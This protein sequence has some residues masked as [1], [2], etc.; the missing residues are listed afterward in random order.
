[1]ERSVITELDEQRID[2]L[3]AY[4][5]EYSERN[6]ENIKNLFMQKTAGKHKSNK[7]ILLVAA[8]AAVL[9][10]FSGIALAAFT[11]LDFGRI[12]NSFFNNP[13]AGSRIEVGYS[14][15]SDGM[16]IT[17][18]TA[19]VDEGSAY[20]MLE[21]KD[22]DGRR[23]SDSMRV[24]SETV[25]GMSTSA[26]VYDDTENKAT[27]IVTQYLAG[28]VEIGRTIK[29]S[30]DAVLSG[31]G[32]FENQPLDFDIAA[33]ATGKE[34]VSVEEWV[35]AAG[36]NSYG[37]TSIEETIMLLKPGEMEVV[38]DGINWAVI[39]NF[40]V[41]DGRLHLQY[42]QTEEYSMSYNYGFEHLSL[43]DVN[44]EVIPIYF[45][46]NNSDFFELVFDIGDMSDLASLQLAVS[47]MSIKHII[48]GPWELSFSVDKEMPKKT[49]KA[50]PADSPF[51]IGIE[52]TT[53]PMSTTIVMSLSDQRQELT[54]MED[55]EMI[56]YMMGY[57]QR[58]V[59]YVEGFPLPHLT[60]DDGSIIPLEIGAGC[61]YDIDTGWAEYVSAYFDIEKLHSITFCEQEYLFSDTD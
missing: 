45:S 42:R 54:D 10:A 29:L 14:V 25:L 27:I 58:V 22:L 24:M 13:S 8:I 23:L 56:D 31:L 37:M 33:Y 52:I 46:I 39:S 40:G 38:I 35:R 48:R 41:V 34:T 51:I 16:E 53:S 11:D 21:L 57:V 32:Y 49:I 15:V 18:L 28:S 5:P 9:V 1:M 55:P 19:F 36:G 6:S 60:L 50:V 47:G 17:L 61:M 4:T 7:R 20:L 44:G 59:D 26:V 43:L 2:E 30:I 3:L 12:F